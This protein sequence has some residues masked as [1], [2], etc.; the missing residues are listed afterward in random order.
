MFVDELES[1]TLL[2]AEI[3]LFFFPDVN[4]Q[5]QLK[6]M[7]VVVKHG[8]NRFFLFSLLVYLSRILNTEECS[9]ELVGSMRDEMHMYLSMIMCA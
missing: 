9:H 7:A 8:K 3:S 6:T 2:C 4:K 1:S 5:L